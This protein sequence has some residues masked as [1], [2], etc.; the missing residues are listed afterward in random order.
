MVGSRK[1]APLLLQ[2][3]VHG[4]LLAAALCNGVPLPS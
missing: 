4:F 2:K 3:R 1:Q